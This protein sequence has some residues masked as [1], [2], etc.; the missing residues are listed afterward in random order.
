MSL[1]LCYIWVEDYRNFQNTGF[2]F[3][4]EEKF[5]FDLN[6]SLLSMQHLERL[7]NNFFGD[8]I[9]EVTGLI[10]KNGSGKSNAL[11]LVCKLLKGGKTGLTTPFFIVTKEY[12][13]FVCYVSNRKSIFTDSNI[14]IKPYEHNIDPLKIVYF[15]NVFDERVHNFDRDISDISNNYRY[16]RNRFSFNT[17][18]K[19]DFEKQVRFIHSEFYHYLDIKTPSKVRIS[20]KLWEKSY[21]ESSQRK[22][23][24]EE[25]DPSILNFFLDLRRRIDDTKEENKFYYLIVYVY[26]L[27][28]INILN[29]RYSIRRKSIGAPD[30]NSIFIELVSLTKSFEDKRYTRTE[31]IIKELLAWMYKVVY[32]DRFMEYLK[33]NS[34]LELM[35]TKINM[36]YHFRSN[37]S[38]INIIPVSE[39]S[40][41]RKTE[42]FIF[43]FGQLNRSK[44]IEYFELFYN[45][46][47]FTI[48]W[49]SI[50][51]GYKAYLNI[52]SLIYFEL[53]RVRKQNAL[54]CIDEGD[55]YLHPQWQIEFF[56]K[57]INVLPKIYE[58]DIQLILTSHSPFLLSDLPKQNV[59][60][61]DSSL[62]EEATI[63]GI[64]LEKQ[65]FAGNIYNLYAEPFFLGNNRTSI[66]AKKKIERLIRFIDK[67]VAGVTIQERERLIQEINLI[68][69]E[70]IRLHLLKRLKND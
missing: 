18:Q 59:T 68:G 64:E 34:E 1:K 62:A 6:T 56:D 52:F 61:I 51:S 63:D 53:R 27:D 25:I 40:H 7:P 13:Q 69:D 8:R 57:L 5:Y 36:L 45:T 15:S 48:D 4:S 58:G 46:K 9:I 54:I 50:S 67:D 23:I 10:G 12:N 22:L 19:T 60:I 29:P 3:S 42:Y 30:F 31:E 32:S 35:R 55:L 26:S 20:S 17:N 33:K 37:I 14:K 39:G 24:L 66:F 2:N 70:V 43:D 11:E 44:A 21:F 16:P 38:D 41:S 47:L 49:T 28:I 65:T